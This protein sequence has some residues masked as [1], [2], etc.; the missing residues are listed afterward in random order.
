MEILEILVKVSS[1]S[2]YV[3]FFTW[4][5]EFYQQ[6]V[7]YGEQFMTVYQGWGPLAWTFAAWLESVFPLLMLSLIT[8]FNIQAAQGMF[9]D[10]FGWIIGFLLTYVGTTIGSF[11]MFYFWRYLSDK[12]RYFRNRKKKKL[13]PEISK[14][15]HESDKGVVGLFSLSCIPLLPSSII[16]F[17][18]AF[19]KMKTSLFIKTT[20]IAKFMMMLLM[21][22]FASFFDWLFDDL[23]RALI[24]VLVIVV[25]SLLLNKNEDHIVN[26]MKKLLYRFR[27][28]RELDEKSKEQ[29][30]HKIEQEHPV[31]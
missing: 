8:V 30:E 13:D 16:N 27:W 20:A 24:T 19:T 21:S 28:I 22:I 2:W 1:L 12:F 31:K 5:N 29:K 23:I 17:T 9:G 10:F 14:A 4:I 6:L 11:T 7:S 15:V 26:A 3:D 25:F 18:Y